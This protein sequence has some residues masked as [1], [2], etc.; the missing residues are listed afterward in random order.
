QDFA[1]LRTL[2]TKD[3]IDDHGPHFSGPA[4]AYVSFLERALP[5]MHVG[6][7]FVC[8]HLISVD[9]DDAEGEVYAIAWH[10]IPDGAGGLKHDLQGVRYIDQYRR[11]GGRWLFA[12]RVLSFDM[13]RI[14][15][16]APHGD[17]PDPEKDASYDALS[18]RIFARGPRA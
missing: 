4:D 1:L 8:N 18:R 11:E 7:H 13:K 9:G 10:L 16:A 6:A 2:Y 12:K 15:P 14:E 5:H 17:K 3:A